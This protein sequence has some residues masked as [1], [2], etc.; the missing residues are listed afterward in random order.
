MAKAK[1]KVNMTP[2][3]YDAVV[4]PV[5]TEKSQLGSEQ[6]K[7]TFKIA[8]WATKAQVKSAVEGIFGTEVVKVNVINVKG[9][10]KRFKGTLGVRKDE[11]KAIVTLAAGKTIDIASAV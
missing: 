5:I 7:V 10:T 4:S 2:A 1:K 11:K 6:N 8:P 9:K 3:M